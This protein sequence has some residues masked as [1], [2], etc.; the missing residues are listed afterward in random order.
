[1]SSL[2]AGWHRS[3]AAAGARAADLTPG[4]P[5]VPRKGHLAITDRAPYGPWTD[6][7]IAML[8]KQQ[9]MTFTFYYQ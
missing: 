3:A 2:P 5:I 8:G 7:M 6:D 4:L 9:E 1:M